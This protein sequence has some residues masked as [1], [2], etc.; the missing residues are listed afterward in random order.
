MKKVLLAALA[1]FTFTS[2]MAINNEPKPGLTWQGQVGMN[3][4]NLRDSH[5]NAK[6]GANVGFYGQYML[7]KAHG[8][9]I[10]AG[11]NY[12]MK[13]GKV[14]Y[15]VLDGPFLGANI[16]EKINL[17]YLNIPIHI[18]FQYNIIPELGV[19]ADFGP[20]LGVAPGGRKVIDYT[21]DIYEDYHYNILKHHDKGEYT[22]GPGIQRFDWGLGLRFGA[23]YNQH[24]SLNVGL[25]W[26]L[27]DILRDSY[28]SQNA[29]LH[30]PEYKT[31]NASITLGYRF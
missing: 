11:L 31:F 28:R 17:H 9:Y 30:L 7:E 12:G 25:D 29:L 8:T 22:D 21:Q 18:G 27:T 4:S 6:P 26:G 3:I 24:Y 14:T 5:Y 19:F 16:D 15:D 1:L 23:E 20:Y 10:F 13:G 2:A